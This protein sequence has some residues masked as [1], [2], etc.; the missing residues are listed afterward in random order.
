MT[1]LPVPGLSALVSAIKFMFE[2]VGKSVDAPSEKRR[3]WFE[4]H[5]DK[6]YDQLK[7]IH[8]D[9][10]KSFSVALAAIG[11]NE[12]LEE[13]IRVLKLERPKEILTRQEVKENLFALR[14]YRLDKRKKPKIALTFYDYVAAVD[15]YLNAASPIPFGETWYTYFI[16]RLSDLIESGAEHP[17]QDDFDACAQGKK[18]PKIAA[19]ELS[20]AIHQNMPEA[21]RKV[22][23]IYAQ[24]RVQCLSDV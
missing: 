13:G 20:R 17:L 6:S 11:D 7:S 22:Q 1:T 21:F 8:D 4:D 10:T 9:Y 24:L 16:N 2:I 12:N 15:S 3:K 18:A 19:E 14:D 5:I 23:E